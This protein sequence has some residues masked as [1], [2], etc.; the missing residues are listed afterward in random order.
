MPDARFGANAT[1]LHAELREH[2]LCLTHSLLT[3][4]TNRAVGPS[5]QP[6]AF[7]AARVASEDDSGLV[8]RGARMLATLPMADAIMVFPSTLLKNTPD[9]APTRSA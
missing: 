8:I 3:P 5:Q 6:D 4:Q 7:I 9:D 2:D 1:R